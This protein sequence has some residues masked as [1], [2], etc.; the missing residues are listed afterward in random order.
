MSSSRDPGRP[1]APAPADT[2]AVELDPSRPDAWRPASSSGGSAA[3]GSSRLARSAGLIGLATMS[4]RVLGLAR[5]TLLAYFFG[6]GHDMDAYQVAFRIPNLLRDLFAEG[7]MSSAFVPAFTR[8][9]TLNGK[10]AAWRLGNLV[11]NALALVTGAAVVLGVVFCRPLV[12]F[13]AGDFASVPGKLEMAV[14]M[15]RL[16]FPFLTMIA[17]AAAC[18][19]MLNSLRRFFIPALSPAMFNVGTIATLVVLIPIFRAQGIRPIF[20]AAIGTVVG[21]VGQILLQWPALRR[22]GFRYRPIVDVRDPALRQVLVLMGPGTIGLAAV[23]VNVLINTMLATGQGEGA[24]SFLNF[25]FRLMY[26]PI[27]I[28]GL[29]IATAAIP[30]LSQHAA[31]DNRPAM[32]ATLSSAIRM[33][34]MLTVPATIGLMV[35]S[36]PIV[37]LLYE[38]GSFTPA[39]TAGTVSAVLFYAPGLIGYSA[40]KIAVPAFYSLQDSRT[41]VTVGAVS[42]MVNVAM[43]LALVRTLGYRGLALGTSIAALFNAAVLLWLLRQRLGGI[44]GSRVLT[45][46]VKVLAAS[47]V[48]G[49]AAWGVSRWSGGMLGDASLVA[50]L[51]RVGAGIGAGLGVLALAAHLLRIAEFA[52][53]LRAV[54]ARITGRRAS[55]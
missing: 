43:N 1:S 18:M 25:A 15:A 50:R 30:S 22:E 23:Q 36:T 19:G 51:V 13:V 5:D 24:V 17:V 12:S 49:A 28:F 21:G 39:A 7:A 37:R 3:T 38:W 44:D 10:P 32:R 35:L 27:G 55:A 47:I 8:V 16:M 40:V 54:A 31:L 52:E 53:A 14:A 29:S 20:A 2:P 34:L 9:L 33:M 46:F 6:A 45:A 4:S 42:V 11:I 41:P 48:M 26:L